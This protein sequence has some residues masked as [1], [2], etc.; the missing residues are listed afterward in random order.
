M[1]ASDWTTKTVTRREVLENSDKTDSAKSLFV[2]DIWG[3]PLITNGETLRALRQAPRADANAAALEV[4]RLALVAR[5]QAR[6]DTWVGDAGNVVV[7]TDRLKLTIYCD[8]SAGEVEIYKECVRVYDAA[9]CHFFPDI[10]ELQAGGA[11]GRPPRS[12]LFL[13]FLPSHGASRGL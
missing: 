2:L 3:D 9:L 11:H 1:H 12:A 6:I 5:Q 13:T 8:L 10:C 4:A 7:E